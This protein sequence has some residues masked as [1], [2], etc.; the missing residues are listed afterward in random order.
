MAKKAKDTRT[1]GEKE[2]HQNLLSA[3]LGYYNISQIGDTSNIVEQAK[4]LENYAAMQGLDP[5]ADLNGL[6]RQAGLFG[7]LIPEEQKSAREKL[8]KATEA[9]F[10]YALNGLNGEKA[11]GLAAKLGITKEELEL[12]GKLSNPEATIEDTKKA[13]SGIYEPSSLVSHYIALNQ[14]PEEIK[15]AAYGA[16]NRAEMRRRGEFVY[17]VKDK[18]TG[19]PIMRYE[20]AKAKAYITENI[21]KAPEQIATDVKMGIGSHLA[22]IVVA[23]EMQK[24]QKAA[25]AQSE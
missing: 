23:R 8:I 9:N 13:F 4:G 19:K 2:G 20:G 10:A 11:V 1:P 22:S 18:A 16:L 6:P 5:E 7:Q 24:A 12:E 25:E 15:Q 21:E 3:G 14:N 17:A